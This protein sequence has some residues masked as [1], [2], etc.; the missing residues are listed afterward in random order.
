MKAVMAMMPASQNSLATAPMR[1]MFS[2]RS[3]AEKPRPNRLANSSPWRS[4]SMAGAAFRPWRML[5][6]SRTKLCM[7]AECSLWSTRLATVLLPQALRPVNQTTQPAWPLRFSRSC[8]GNGVFV[9][10]DLNLRFVGHRAKSPAG[11]VWT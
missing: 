5:S 11:G 4:L 1:R 2:S 7:P 3:W 9:P 6:P 10:M 8:A